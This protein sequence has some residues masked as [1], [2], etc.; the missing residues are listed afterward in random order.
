MGR[1]S[2]TLLD[3]QLLHMFFDADG[4]DMKTIGDARQFAHQLAAVSKAFT[5]R[6]AGLIETRDKRIGDLNAQ[7][8]L[9]HKPGKIPGLGRNNP[10]H[11]PRGLSTKLI[12]Q[13]VND[14]LAVFNGLNIIDGLG[15]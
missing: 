14:V 15:L 12:A 9:V 8:L 13:A 6:V 4:H 2:K 11:Q 10:Y 1:H 5:D 3:E 7:N